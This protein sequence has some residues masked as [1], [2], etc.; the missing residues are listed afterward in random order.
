MFVFTLRPN[1]FL[2]CTSDPF[3]FS[4]LI[5]NCQYRPNCPLPLEYPNTPTCS[6]DDRLNPPIQ[7]SPTPT[8]DGLDMWSRSNPLL[9]M[10]PTYLPQ[11][12]GVSNL[13]PYDIIPSGPSNRR[14][15]ACRSVLTGAGSLLRTAPSDQEGCDGQSANTVIRFLKGGSQ[16]RF[17]YLCCSRSGS[18][19]RWADPVSG[20]GQ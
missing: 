7:T 17:S 12:H 11:V 10:S 14:P 19:S 16:H 1:Q 15:P 9:K 18:V 3:D 6:A 20:A 4:N 2:P 8:E 13:W 5:L